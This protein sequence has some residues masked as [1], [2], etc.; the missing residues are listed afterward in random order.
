MAKRTHDPTRKGIVDQ[1]YEQHKRKLVFQ[2]AD[3]G[4]RTLSKQSSSPPKDGQEYLNRVYIESLEYP[5]VF[6]QNESSNL[7]DKTS[8]IN[9]VEKY[10]SCDDR[11]ICVNML[12]TRAQA[13]EIA[14]NLTS[15]RS[16]IANQAP[17]VKIKKNVNSL[18]KALKAN[19]LNSTIV[20][21]HD[22]IMRKMH[23]FNEN[24]IHKLIQGHT[25][26][27]SCENF[28]EKDL[29]CIFCYLLNIDIFLKDAEM[30]NIRELCKKAIE[31]RKS[32]SRLND[33]DNRVVALNLIII[34]ISFVFGQKDLYP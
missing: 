1:L 19:S 20:N 33:D 21:P 26:L 8:E 6:Y 4:E 13:Q 12:P 16:K 25:K 3:F 22:Y 34:T 5:T 15:L 9:L 14:K 11:E 27:L 2:I 18:L 7:E 10:F 28:T 23:S 32:L 30:H 24:S 17:K 31:L 29:I